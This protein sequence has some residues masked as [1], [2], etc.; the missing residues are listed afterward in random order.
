M[1]CRNKSNRGMWCIVVD[2]GRGTNDGLRGGNPL[3]MAN[4]L[5]GVNWRGVCEMRWWWR[6]VKATVGVAGTVPGGS[7]GR[8][9]GRGVAW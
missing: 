5:D 9:G 3:R 1:D 6:R 8:V 2:W 4:R 7:F